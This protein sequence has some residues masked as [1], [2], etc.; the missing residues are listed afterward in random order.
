[1]MTGIL[2]WKEKTPGVRQK[3][4]TLREIRILHLRM[5]CAEV[6]REERTPEALLRRRVLAAAKK[7]RKAGVHM[8]VLPE[9]LPGDF[10]PERMGLQRVSTVPLRQMIAADWV[11]LELRKK[12]LL[13]AE[14]RVAVSAPQLTGEVVRTVT[15]LV[16]RHR[17]VLLDVPRGTE[18]FSRRLRR[19]YGVSLLD[20]TDPR[21]MEKAEARV[22][23][24]Q[25]EEQ[26]AENPVV[27]SLADESVPLPALLLPPVLESQL[28]AGADRGQLLALLLEAGALRPGQVALSTSAT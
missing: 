5:L 1:M 8:V 12:N 15:E 19:E 28:P 9:D 4:V 10:L 14:T 23:F 22:I 2:L 20:G 6:L 25:R 17:Y 13:S 21:Q 27:L 16:L 18:E 3:A 7:L 24:D 26:R 11:R